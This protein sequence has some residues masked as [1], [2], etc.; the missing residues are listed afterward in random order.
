MCCYWTIPIAGHTALII[1][2]LQQVPK[3]KLFVHY[4]LQSV[5]VGCFIYRS[6]TSETFS[7][8]LISEF[9]VSESFSNVSRAENV[10]QAT[11]N[12]IDLLS[13][14]LILP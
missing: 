9:C 8:I 3:C 14:A 4:N 1:S 2:Y 5:V 11:G 6:L 10:Y 13:V 12:V 7:M